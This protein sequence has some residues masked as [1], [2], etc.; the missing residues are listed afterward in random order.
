MPTPKASDIT[1]GYANHKD[2]TGHPSLPGL[3]GIDQWGKFSQAIERWEG[4]LGRKAPPPT[5]AGRNGNPRLAAPFVEWMMGLPKGWVTD[6]EFTRGKT[7]TLLGNGV[8]P[9]QGALAIGGLI[10]EEMGRACS[11]Q[12]A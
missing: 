7:F 3:V 1:K 6:F 5:E 2:S 9:Q 11:R 4:A 10:D 12:V 8:V